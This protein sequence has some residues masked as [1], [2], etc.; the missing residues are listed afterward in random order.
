M[1]AEV[2]PRGVI[3]RDRMTEAQD[4]PGG[5]SRVDRVAQKEALYGSWSQS[6][7]LASLGA[8][9]GETGG[10]KNLSRGKQEGEVAAMIG[11]HTTTRSRSWQQTRSRNC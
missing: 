11:T 6:D 9:P 5:R 10:G 7:R 2:L 8:P 4:F 3:S 1:K